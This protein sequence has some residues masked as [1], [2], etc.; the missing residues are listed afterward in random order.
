MNLYNAKEDSAFSNSSVACKGNLSVMGTREGEQNKLQVAFRMLRAVLKIY[1]K[2]SLTWHTL[3]E[4]LRISAMV[5]SAAAHFGS[6]RPAR[7]DL[8]SRL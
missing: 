2:F 3:I 6:R 8:T 4:K 7:R 5:P 1:T